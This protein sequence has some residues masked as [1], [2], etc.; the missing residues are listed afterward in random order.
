MVR[1]AKFNEDSFIDAAIEVGA[2]CGIAAVSISAIAGKAGAP[3]GS[4]YH[5]FESRGTI[6]ARAWLRVKADFR[7]AV[8]SHWSS[9]DTWPAVAAFLDWCRSK[10]QHARFLLQCEDYSLFNEPL[11]PDFHA[12][13]ESEQA[14]L[15]LC[16]T[17]CVRRMALRMNDDEARAMLRFVLIDAPIAI[18]KPYLLQNLPIPATTANML[19]ASHDAVCQWARHPD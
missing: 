2:Q 11:P 1:L 10:P 7:L 5:R 16:F 19:R 6:L 17:Q 12:Q 9:G 14:A 3:T 13:M 15:D 8:A 4:V 18:V